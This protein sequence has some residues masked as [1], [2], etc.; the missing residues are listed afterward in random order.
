[1]NEYVLGSGLRTLSSPIFSPLA[2]NSM[3]STLLAIWAVRRL[4]E[5]VAGALS[6]A[7]SWGTMIAEGVDKIVSGPHQTIVPGAML[8]L[9]VLS[10][11]VVGDAVRDAFD[12]R[13]KVRVER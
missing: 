4:I 2:K 11:N 1:M 13:A 9:T 7:P 3:R 5:I 12:P 10:L 8:V 6:T